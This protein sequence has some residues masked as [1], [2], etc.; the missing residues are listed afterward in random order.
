[1]S[2]KCVEQA[3]LVL[4]WVRIGVKRV[5]VGASRCVIN[6]LYVPGRPSWSMTLGNR[7]LTR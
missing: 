7:V 3:F 2:G 6:P 4:A 5:P 1:M